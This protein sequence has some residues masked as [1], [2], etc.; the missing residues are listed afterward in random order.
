MRRLGLRA[1][2]RWLVLLLLGLAVV[3]GFSR[4]VPYCMDE[5]LQYNE[6]SYRYYPNNRLNTFDE[7][8]GLY[9]LDVFGSGLVLPLRCYDYMGVVPALYYFPLFAIWKDPISARF[10][11][12]VFL[13][14][15][16]LL[17][18]RIVRFRSEYLF[19]GLL[20]FFPYLFQHLVETGL[21]G[22]QIVC[23]LGIYLLLSRWFET[24]TWRRTIGVAGLVFLGVWTKLSFLWYGPALLW[25]AAGFAWESRA[26]WLERERRRG[27]AL[28]ATLGAAVLL[29]LLSVLFASTDPADPGRYPYLEQVFG[30]LYSARHGVSQLLDI[31]RL[32]SLPVFDTLWNPWRAAERVFAPPADLPWALVYSASLYAAAPLLWLV[33]ARSGWTQP[34][35]LILRALWAY[36]AFWLTLLMVFLNKQAWAMHHTLLAYPFLVL[37]FL[38]SLEAVRDGALSCGRAKYYCRVVA[39]GVAAFVVLN[40]YYFLSLPRQKVDPE[41]DASRIRLNAR[42]ADAELSRDYFYVVLDWGFYFYQ[43]LYGHRDQSVL[44][45][46]PLTPARARELGKLQARTGRKL[47]FLYNPRLPG[48]DPGAVDRYFRV[49][50]CDLLGDGSPGANA[51]RVLIEEDGAAEVCF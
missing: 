46:S 29:A 34:R 49:I 36:V 30:S 43:A 6:I 10:T 33:L 41:N 40:S 26:R 13:F 24:P 1:A 11:G 5:F 45:V 7:K 28:Q 37:S 18:A 35:R 25:L 48:H 42:L 23:L 51:W 12:I 15:Q 4:V 21:V 2:L 27:A 8:P 39:V 32:L 22:L 47:L 31:V 3:L 14:L 17:L 38:I 44:Y 9:D 16:S 20:C 50:A 19:L